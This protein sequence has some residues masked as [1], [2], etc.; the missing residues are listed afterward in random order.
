MVKGSTTEK[1]RSREC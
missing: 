1:Q